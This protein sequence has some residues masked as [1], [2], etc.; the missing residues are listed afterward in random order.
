VFREKA[1][2]HSQFD[3]QRAIHEAE[4]TQLA[5]PSEPA[6][7]FEVNLEQDTFTEEKFKLYENYQRNVHHDPPSRITRSSFTR[8][9]C[10]SPLKA[11]KTAISGGAE[12]KLG[13]YHQ[14][15][16][17][18]GRLVRINVLSH[19]LYDKTSMACHGL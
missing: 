6:H 14:C 15:Y 8:F 5:L 9:L 10:E 12:Q 13:S 4:Y 17:L 2:Q 1:Q 16:R 7:K 11:P 19:T 3:L 18:N